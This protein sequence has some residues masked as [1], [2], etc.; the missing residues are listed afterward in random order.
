MSII[1]MKYINREMKSLALN[2]E[3]V[4][5]LRFI[6]PELTLLIKDSL[7][8]I[9]SLSKSLELMDSYCLC[10]V[11]DEINDYL[12]KNG[13][14]IILYKDNLV[15]DLSF[16]IRKENKEKI[17]KLKDKVKNLSEEE[18]IILFNKEKARQRNIVEELLDI[19][20]TLDEDIVKE[21][22]KEYDF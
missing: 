18:Q 5:E 22:M 16:Y 15:E 3:T 8:E 7:I 19:L 10:D 6:K 2:D 1:N 11:L 12:I 13:E 4:K 20:D 14:Y 21:L 9:D 17:K